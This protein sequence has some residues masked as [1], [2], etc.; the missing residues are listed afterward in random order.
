MLPGEPIGQ[1]PTGSVVPRLRN[2]A[3][4]YGIAFVFANRAREQQD[5]NT[6]ESVV[7]A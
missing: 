3:I 7:D 4:R 2:S 5:A 6:R 1:S